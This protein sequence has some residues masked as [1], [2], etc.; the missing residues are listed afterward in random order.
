VLLL[1]LLGVLQLLLEAVHDG[2]Q[3]W[4]K[5]VIGFVAD[6]PLGP[7]GPAKRPPAIAVSHGGGGCDWA[8]EVSLTTSS[9]LWLR[10][11]FINRCTPYYITL[12]TAG[13]PRTSQVNFLSFLSLFF[14][15]LSLYISLSLS[16]SLSL[17]DHARE[18]DAVPVAVEELLAC[19][20][21]RISIIIIL[22]HR[23]TAVLKA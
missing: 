14:L 3:S 18:W 10:R 15:S 13:Q 16:L 21:I 11:Y 8:G 5:D 2:D 1:H 17:L 6:V 20:L 19:I 23:V 7:R 22:I 12:P 4:R 9:Q